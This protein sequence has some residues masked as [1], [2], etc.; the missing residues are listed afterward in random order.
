MQDSDSGKREGVELDSSFESSDGSDIED[1]PGPSTSTK[2]PGK[3][4]PGKKDK[5][6]PH[7]EIEYERETE[8]PNKSV[9]Y[10]WN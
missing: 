8:A 9:V 7:I 1:T 2:K 6:R 3:K 4:P 10:N 5:K